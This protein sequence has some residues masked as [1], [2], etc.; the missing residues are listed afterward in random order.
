LEILRIVACTENSTAQ[1]IREEMKS[2]MENPVKLQVALTVG[3]ILG[4]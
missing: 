3:K 1:R 4:I 2:L